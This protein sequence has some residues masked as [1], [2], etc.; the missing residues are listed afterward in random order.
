MAACVANTD[1]AVSPTSGISLDSRQS[2]E[3]RPDRCVTEAVVHQAAP[4]S[5]Y[6]GHSLIV[7]L[8]YPTLVHIA[9]RMCI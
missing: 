9:I 6:V 2:C 5:W 4:Q 1:I 7:R 8:H 3:G